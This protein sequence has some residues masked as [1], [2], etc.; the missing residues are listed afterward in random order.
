MM[1]T[2]S[3]MYFDKNTFDVR[4]HQSQIALIIN[5]LHDARIASKID[6]YDYDNEI[7]VLIDLFSS[8][9]PDILNSFVD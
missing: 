3:N 5:A 6:A 9:E 8:V 7:N 4:L 1:K 2:E